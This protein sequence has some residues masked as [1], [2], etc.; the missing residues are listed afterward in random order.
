MGCISSMKKYRKDLQDHT[1][2]YT[3]KTD[4]LPDN[5]DILKDIVYK[6]RSEKNTGMMHLTIAYPLNNGT[7]QLEIIGTDPEAIKK[8]RKLI[9]NSRW[10]TQFSYDLDCHIKREKQ[11]MG[12]LESIAGLIKELDDRYKDRFLYDEG[13]EGHWNENVC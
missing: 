1:D 5:V 2:E 7:S 4:G 8:S 13:V 6:W 9:E 11:L 3:K 12:H 10:L